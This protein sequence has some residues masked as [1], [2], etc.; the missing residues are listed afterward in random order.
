MLGI[1]EEL[2]QNQP[3]RENKDSLHIFVKAEPPISNDI[4]VN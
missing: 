4:L 2:Q 1:S 3:K